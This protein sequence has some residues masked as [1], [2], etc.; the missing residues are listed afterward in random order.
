MT[1]PPSTVTKAAIPAAGPG[2]RFLP[3]ATAMPKEISKEMP[4]VVDRPTTAPAR[5]GIVA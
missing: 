3:A 2:T 1:S 4:P 5:P